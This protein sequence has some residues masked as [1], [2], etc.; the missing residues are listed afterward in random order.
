MPMAG[1][2]TLPEIVGIRWLSAAK[3]L[4]I[5]GFAKTGCSQIA[6][7]HVAGSIATPQVAEWTAKHLLAW[8]AKNLLKWNVCFMKNSISTANQCK[9]LCRL[10]FLEINIAT[11]PRQQKPSFLCIKVEAGKT[12]R[13][14]LWLPRGFFSIAGGDGEIRTHDSG[15]PKCFLSR[16]VPSAT[17]PHLHTITTAKNSAVIETVIIA[18]CMTLVNSHTRKIFKRFPGRMLYAGRGQ[19][20]P[21]IFHQSE[22]RF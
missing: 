12:K 9:A 2:W 5:T 18:V 17:R 3:R 1:A 7:T 15:Y 20:T 14:S 10:T 19:P 8:L 16:E 11:K 13:K 21:C 6:Q 22:P 4:R